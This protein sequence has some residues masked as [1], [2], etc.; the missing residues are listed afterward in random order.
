MIRTLFTKVTTLISAFAA[1]VILK[2]LLVKFFFSFKQTKAKTDPKKELGLDFEDLY[3]KTA[4]GKLIHGWFIRNNSDT[5]DV[6]KP[7][8]ILTHGW[9]QT[10]DYLLPAVPIFRKH[11][12][13]VF[14][15]ESR[16]HGSSSHDGIST[17]PKFS[18]DIRAAIDYLKNDPVRKKDVD[19][20][21]IGLLGFSLGAAG[22]FH[23]T[24]H[25]SSVR[26]LISMGSFCIHTHVLERD[27][28]NKGVRG[29]LL[30][31]IMNELKALPFLAEDIQPKSTITMIPK[32]RPVLII[33][34][35]NDGGVVIA[36]A[37][38]LAPLNQ[39]DDKKFVVVEG[40]KHLNLFRYPE[41]ITEIDQF[42]ARLEYSKS[43]CV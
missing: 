31:F 3:F 29:F 39:S 27:V 32:D 28:R 33:H 16:S 23:A 24:A 21:R 6:A 34:G 35:T 22:S 40:A 37:Y 18:Q 11:G 13:N 25:D 19:P 8:A 17:L 5:T 4:N 20:T 14:L 2:R 41:T 7:T 10:G 43:N 9:S 36:E 12:F 30:K 38:E 26:F 1:I 42:L 15:I